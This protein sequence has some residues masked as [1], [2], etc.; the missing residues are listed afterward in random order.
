MMEHSSEWMDD[1]DTSYANL[2]LVF[3]LGLCWILS[4]LID[5]P[6]PKVNADSAAEE[7]PLEV[8]GP[9]PKEMEQFFDQT[10]A[11]HMTRYQIPGATISVGKDRE[12]FFAKGYGLAN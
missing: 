8:P 7:V 11:E 6:Q 4:Y 12:V 2:L 9:D 3:A 5:E 1:M 10:I